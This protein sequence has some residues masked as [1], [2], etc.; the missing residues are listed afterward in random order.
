MTRFDFYFKG[1]TRKRVVV[2]LGVSDEKKNELLEK[3]KMTGI[4]EVLFGE[5]MLEY[6]VEEDVC[7]TEVGH[8]QNYK[9]GTQLIFSKD[10]S[11]FARR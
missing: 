7:V 11:I 8:K 6:L 5:E 3:A 4:S 9:K 1:E 2:Y 10:G